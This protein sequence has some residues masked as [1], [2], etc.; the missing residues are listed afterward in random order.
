M[1]RFVIL[2]TLIVLNLERLSAQQSPGACTSAAHHNF[3]FWVGQWV[4]TDTG[5][6]VVGKSTIE[7]IA[8]GCVI[9]EH[10]QPLGGL[11]GASINWY[12]AGDS[13]WHQQWVGGG[14]WIARWSGS[15]HG[16]VMTMTETESSLPV[17]AGRNRM[18][19]TLLPDGRVKQWQENS[20][21][22]GKTWTGQFTG[23]YRK[24]G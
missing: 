12:T 19:W 3:D 24:T 15:F 6:H 7:R 14:G 10:W 9:S 13:T 8:A 17:A 11:D 4:V 16:G 1:T 2:A 21:D 18:N 5:G 23:Y 20:K 22:G